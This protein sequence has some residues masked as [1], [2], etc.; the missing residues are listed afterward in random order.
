M[1]GYIIGI[2][3][4][5]CSLLV[6]YTKV[7]FDYAT[8]KASLIANTTLLRKIEIMLDKTDKAI[9]DHERRLTIIETQH[10]ANHKGA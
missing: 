10:K 7:I 3:V 4:G 8:I 6:L 2:V 5:V 1:T 9:E